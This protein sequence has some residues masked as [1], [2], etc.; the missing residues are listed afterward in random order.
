MRASNHGLTYTGFANVDPQFQEFTVDLRSALE[1]I[2]AAHRA[3][4]YADFAGHLQAP[5]PGGTNPPCPKQAESL[6]MP[7]HY[8]WK[9][10]RC[11]LPTSSLPRQNGATPTERDQPVS[12]L[13]ASLIAAGRQSGGEAQESQIETQHDCGMILIT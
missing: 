7:S 12:A 5:G 13:A 4:R 10:A 3:N 9:L 6:A 1:W 8:G 11:G 2:L